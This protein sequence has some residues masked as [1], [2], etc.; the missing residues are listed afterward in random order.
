M[1]LAVS[2]AWG[3]GFR[4]RGRPSADGIAAADVVQAQGVITSLTRSKDG[5]VKMKIAELQDSEEKKEKPETQTFTLDWRTMVYKLTDRNRQ[6][7]REQDKIDDVVEDVNKLHHRLKDLPEKESRLLSSYRGSVYVYSSG[8]V[9][10]DESINPFAAA[11]LSEALRA[12]QR[13]EEERRNHYGPGVKLRVDM[14]V[15]VF[16]G[17]SNDTTYAVLVTGKKA[18]PKKE[19]PAAES[20]GKAKETEAARKLKYAKGLSRDAENAMGADRERL[21]RLA[22]ARLQEVVDKFPGTTAALEAKKLLEDK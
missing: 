21:N 12:Y 16:A 14:T 5:K 6:I 1:L 7:F 20:P 2:P 18:P 19:K 17:R 10:V 15:V 22:K 11:D 13:E 9:N 4:S 3:Q 8:W